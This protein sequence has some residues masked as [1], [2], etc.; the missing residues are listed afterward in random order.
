MNANNYVNF[1]LVKYATLLGVLI[2]FNYFLWSINSWQILRFINFFFLIGALV[3]FFLAKKFNYLWYLKLIII[4]LL[5]ICLGTPT[6]PIDSRTFF[7]FPGKILF[8]E[9]NLYVHLGDYM[10]TI[11]VDGHDFLDTVYSRPKLAPSLSA[12]FAQIIGFWNDIFPKTS[13]VVII[14]PAIIFLI[15]FFKDRVLIQL[16]LF[17]MLFFSGK[18]FVNGLMD[19]ILSL[20]FVSCILVTYKISITKN[21][22][23]A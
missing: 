10:S 16:W 4:L 18:L 6:I 14:F 15:S 19:G 5:I 23:I 12:T 21:I 20:Y 3:Y 2:T 22:V 13:N 7:L 17:L 11:N 1:N 9:S 8:Y